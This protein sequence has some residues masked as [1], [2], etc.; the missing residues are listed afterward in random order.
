M[1]G[2][3]HITSVEK[4]LRRDH[5][6]THSWETKSLVCEVRRIIIS[7]LAVKAVVYDITCYAVL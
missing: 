3:C 7:E 2:L 4:V 1:A 5:Y 6:Q